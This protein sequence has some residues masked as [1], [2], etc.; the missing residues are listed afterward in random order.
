M[1][2]RIVQRLALSDMID[3]AVYS[4]SMVSGSTCND[5]LPSAGYVFNGVTVF[6]N[7]KLMI[8][9]HKMYFD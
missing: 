7:V 1:L 5:A 8:T 9:S 2:Y 4:T 3:I 6:D